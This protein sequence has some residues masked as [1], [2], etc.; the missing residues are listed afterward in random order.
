MGL[1]KML[2]AGGLSE[3]L[4]AYAEIADELTVAKFREVDSQESVDVIER[5]T[6]EGHKLESAEW[7]QRIVAREGMDETTAGQYAVALAKLANEK[8]IVA[9]L[10]IELKAAERLM[11]FLQAAMPT[12]IYP[13]EVFIAGLAK[14]EK[15]DDDT[16]KEVVEEAAASF[17]GDADDDVVQLRNDVDGM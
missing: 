17:T 12:S 1:L 9:S 4:F 15:L 13:P 8:A 7:K 2:N 5:A 14:E 3:F 6:F 10:E 16:V 11:S